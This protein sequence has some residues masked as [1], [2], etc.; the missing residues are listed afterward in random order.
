MIKESKKVALVTGGFDPLHKGHI[1]YFEAAKKDADLLVVGLNSDKWLIEKKGYFFLSWKERSAII[2]SLGVV[3]DVIS[4][5]DDD[6]TAIDAINVCLKRYKK[7]VFMNG[8]DRTNKNIPELNKFKS[9]EVEFRFGIGGNKKINSSS[10]LLDNFYETTKSKKRKFTNAPWGTHEIIYDSKKN[11]KIKKII[12]NVN[13][14][15]SL[16]YHNHRSEHWIIVQGKCQVQIDDTLQNL[17]EGDYVYIPKLSVHRIKNISKKLKL[18][19]IEVNIGDYIEEDDI[20][21]LDDKYGRTRL[22]DNS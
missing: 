20:V 1:N 11:Y 10:H 12:V 7:I 17:E 18:I 19:F 13:G 3:D 8:G 2:S 14:S 21:R 6:N 4:F 15:L 22:N 5:D 16:Q 9:Q